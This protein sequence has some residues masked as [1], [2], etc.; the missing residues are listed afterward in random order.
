M[1]K[2]SKLIDQH[3]RFYRQNEKKNFDKARRFYRGDFY[4][5]ADSGSGTAGNFLCSKNLIYAIADTAVS[6]LLG[7]NPAVAAVARNPNSQPN[8]V[9]VSGLIEYIFETNRFRRKA[10]TTLI[11]AVLCKRGI[12]KTGWDAQRDIPVV[13]AVNPSQIFFDLTVR[14]P[15]DI[16]YWIEATVISYDEFKNRVET[17]QYKGENLSDVT[18][19]RYPK[20]LLDPNQKESS[21]NLRDV[22]EWVTVY[23]YYDREKGIMQ[24]YV[25]QADAVVFEQKIDYIPYSMYTLNQSGVDCLGLSEVQ[26]VLHQQETVNDLLTHMKQ[27]T[28]LMIPRILFDSG[29]I[30]EEDLNKAVE[31]SAGAFVGI[32]PQNS[33]A[34]RTLATL[35]YEMPMPQNPVGVK[36]F[37]ARQED[38]AAFISA[39]AEAARGQVTGART[40]TEMAIIDAQMQTRLATREGHLNDAIED[41]AKKCF[42][43]CK[44]YMKE[45]RMVRISGNRKWAE[46]THKTIREVEVD[47]KMVSYSPIR[48]NPAVMSETLLQ[49][50]PFLAQNPN[51]DTRR[52][53]E[54]VVAGLSLP[55]RIVMPE[56]DVTQKVAAEAAMAQQASLGGAAGGGGGGIPPEIAAM[57]GAE[58][59]EAPGGGAAPEASLAAGGGAPIREGAPEA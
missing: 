18:P 5:T 35:F 33:E 34:L 7:P 8:A 41:V 20:W 13:R 17:G 44:K 10:A 19:D 49:L 37:I 29:R 25:K 48:Q 31:A 22:F 11:D 46:L 40:A 32:A 24:H 2:L 52:L 53:T 12:F 4:S 3:V 50:L 15:D 27:I 28:Y 59:G 16:R 30:T 21:Q 26:L 9:S 43:L 38:D 42:Y 58:G 56:E 23:E 36:E 6:A 54:E 51:I 45:P 14:D 57:L 1:P 55:S 47:F 39:L